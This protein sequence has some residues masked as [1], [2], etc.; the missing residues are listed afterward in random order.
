MRLFR[1]D[2]LAFFFN[3]MTRNKCFSG[4]LLLVGLCTS[5]A[6][7]AISDLY[8]SGN[9]TMVIHQTSDA[10]LSGDTSFNTYCLKALSEIQL[11]RT[12]SAIQ[13]LQEALQLF[14][15]N[16]RIRKMLAGQL[17]EAGAYQEAEDHYSYFARAANRD[18][19]A[20]TKLARIATFKRQYDRAI[21]LLHQLLSI[22]SVNFSSLVM[23]GEILTSKDDTTAIDYYEKAYGLFPGNQ[24]VACALGNWYIRVG[25][26]HSAVLLCEEVLEQDSAN[27]RFLKLLGFGCYKME[28]P[29]RS[30]QYFTRAIT[31][32]DSTAFSF[33]YAGI[34]HYL[35]ASF[36]EA[37]RSLTIAADIDS[38]DAE[39]HFFLGSSL[40]NTT[41]KEEA[42]FH[43]EKSLEL[44]QPDPAVIARIYSEQGNIM[45]LETRYEKAYELYQKAWQ[46]DST[47]PVAIYYMASILD[48]SLHRS[49]EALADYR[50]FI[51]KLDRMPDS[52]IKRKKNRQIPTIRE[53]V[54][55]RI[56]LLQEEL[57]FLDAQ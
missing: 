1:K 29:D 25:R 22:D 51:E 6:Q 4:I 57:F 19:E 41:R 18:V 52:E 12:D 27:I 24:Q 35:Q 13:T 14:P 55:D 38:T 9:Y 36:S 37:I 54:E 26:P 31:L 43:L 45:R 15:E 49:K 30:I 20:L 46:A 50:L 47:N 3:I 34:A 48:N 40:A 28:L 8:D 56:E 2:D 17:F 44:I 21:R 7:E 16:D 39:I 5:H 11:G 33:K 23:L 32:G 42:M 53:I 10:L